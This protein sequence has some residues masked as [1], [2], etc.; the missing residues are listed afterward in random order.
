[1]KLRESAGKTAEQFK[2]AVRWFTDRVGAEGG[3]ARDRSSSPC[4]ARTVGEMKSEV[5]QLWA[6]AWPK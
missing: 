3:S 5:R 4:T 2:E 1:M 6:G